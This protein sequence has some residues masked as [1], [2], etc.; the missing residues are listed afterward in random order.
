MQQSGDIRDF[1]DF[2]ELIVILNIGAT[3]WNAT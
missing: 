3:E 1:L 2:M